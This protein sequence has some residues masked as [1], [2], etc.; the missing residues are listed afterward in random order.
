MPFLQVTKSYTAIVAGDG[1][2]VATITPDRGLTWV[3]S[4]V[5][6]ELPGA[7]AGATC[8]VRK[9]GALV[10]P[11]IPTGDTAAGDPPVV[12]M[13]GDALTVEWAGCTPGTVGKVLVLLTEQGPGP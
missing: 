11:I 13:L 12:L 2:A 5:S 10:S 4:Q 9:N 3:V 7:P 8:A 6:V 1:T